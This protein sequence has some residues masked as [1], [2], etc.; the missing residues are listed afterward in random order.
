MADETHEWLDQY[1]LA[2]EERNALSKYDSPE[3]AIKGAANAQKMLG[4]SIR[5]PKEDDDN[6]DE[7][8]ADIK[9]K[10]GLTAPES[11]D[12]Y[13]F[14]IPEDIP[15]DQDYLATVREAAHKAGITN[16]Q[17]KTLVESNNEFVAAR[18]KAQQDQTQQAEQ[19]LKSE[20]GDQFDQ[21]MEL[22][23]RWL[24][25]E[26][27]KELAEE[28]EATGLGN[29]PNLIRFLFKNAEKIEGEGSTVA[30]DSPATKDEAGFLTDEFYS[31][32]EK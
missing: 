19:Q 24:M 25:N 28:L 7:T 17:L 8:I 10:I 16:E 12:E 1:E 22:T 26:G 32:P 21:K 11:P 9:A 23:K 29:N 14:E 31:K 6:R 15:A 2:D 3:A 30:S 13:D 20:F 4:N 18:L 5:L 27:G